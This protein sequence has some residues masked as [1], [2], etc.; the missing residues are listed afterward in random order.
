VLAMMRKIVLGQKVE[1]AKVIRAKELRREMTDEEKTLWCRLRANRMLGLQ[2]RR[3]QIID[4]F[5]VDF[6]CHA[7][8]LV[9]EVNGAVHD[10]QR[11]YDAE[12]DQI[13]ATRGLQILRVTNTEVTTDLDEVLERIA[14]ACRQTDSPP[15]PE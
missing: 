10:E 2:F 5:I 7:A 11:E 1:E 3:Q 12:R 6:Y 13:L 8:G 9:V 15:G 14:A 4:G